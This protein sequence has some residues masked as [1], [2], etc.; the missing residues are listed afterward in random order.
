MILT[1]RQPSVRP[2]QARTGVVEYSVT[3]LNNKAV[4]RTA[5]DNIMV[6]LLQLDR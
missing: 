5:K 4:L 1:R 3:P 6:S 2:R